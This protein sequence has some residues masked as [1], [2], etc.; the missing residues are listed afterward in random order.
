MCA[1]VNNEIPYLKDGELIKDWRKIFSASTALLNENQKIAILPVYVCRSSGEQS[2]AHEATKCK[3]LT[4]SLD[5]L[6]RFI[7]GPKSNLIKA[8]EFFDVK[9]ENANEISR[10]DLS[11]FWFDVLDKGNAAAASTDLIIYKFLQQLPCGVKLF[12][13][14]KETID[15]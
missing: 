9:L 10:S 6:E 15:L 1:S 11:V 3:S 13:K 14:C 2:W 4:D 7:D 12:D 8:S 5:F